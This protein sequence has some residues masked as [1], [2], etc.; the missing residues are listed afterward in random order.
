MKKRILCKLFGHRFINL[1]PQKSLIKEYRCRCC[2]QKF[3][4]DG[5]GRMV[6]LSRYWE[7]NN[8]RF[9]KTFQEKIV[10]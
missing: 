6:K 2:N 10:A 3:T 8:M 4:V 5:Y 7:E 1:H 9:K